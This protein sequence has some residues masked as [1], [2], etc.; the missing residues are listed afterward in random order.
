MSAGHAIRA[1]DA[2]ISAARPIVAALVIILTVGHVR[3]SI[4]GPKPAFSSEHFRTDIFEPKR[5]EARTP[6]EALCVA[7]EPG[8]CKFV[9]LLVRSPKLGAYLAKKLGGAPVIL[10]RGHGDTVVDDSV[11]RATVRAVH[12][13]INA[14][15]QLEAMRLSNNINAMDDEELAYNTIEN[16]DVERPW[17]NLKRYLLAGRMQTLALCQY[18]QHLARN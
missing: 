6:H 15:D 9:V 5:F 13:E 16:F 12:T 8:R 17:N 11:K 1:Q 3:T 7:C 18:C 2:L 14:R 4:C 10:M